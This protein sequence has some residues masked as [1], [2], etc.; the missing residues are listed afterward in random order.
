[1]RGSAGAVRSMAAAQP[2]SSTPATIAASS[3]IQPTQAR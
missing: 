1:M 2:R 3:A